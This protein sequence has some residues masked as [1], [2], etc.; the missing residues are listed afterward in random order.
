MTVQR[1][2]MALYGRASHTFFLKRL[3]T[4]VQDRGTDKP[5]GGANYSANL[6]RSQDLS[7]LTNRPHM[8]S[9][10]LVIVGGSECRRL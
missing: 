9:E 5:R 6:D 1:I 7:R 10:S 4:I 2:I 8:K 3:I